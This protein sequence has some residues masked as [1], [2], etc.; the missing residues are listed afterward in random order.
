MKKHSLLVLLPFALI[1][2]GCG[3][4]GK[5]SIFN[6]KFMKRNFGDFR[7]SKYESEAPH[8]VNLDFGSGV[9]DVTHKGSGILLVTKGEERGLFSVHNGKFVLPVDKYDAGD[10]NTQ[11]ISNGSLGKKFFVGRKTVEEKVYLSV[12][13]DEANKLYEG[14]DGVVSI[15][16]NI[17]NRNEIEGNEYS[18]AK[19]NIDGVMKACAIYNVDQ[20]LKEILTEEQY[21]NKNPYYVSGI[22]MSNY[23]HK[24][25]YMAISQEVDVGTRCSAFNTKKGKFVSSFV[26]PDD[27]VCTITI[28]DHI[29]Y[30]KVR[31]CNERDKKYD[32]TTTPA[33]DKYN[34]ETYSVNY[35]TG[36]ETKIKTKY[37]FGNVNDDLDLVNNKG[38]IKY[39][40]LTGVYEVGKDKILSR[41]AKGLVFNEKLKVV[42]DVSGID[43]TTLYN[44]GDYYIS[45]NNVVYDSKLK[46]VGKFNSVSNDWH[47]VQSNGGY[48]LVDHTGK[49]IYR[50]TAQMIE[51]ISEGYY[52]AYYANK[53]QILK[54]S[55]KE[56]VEVSKEI[57]ATDYT[58]SDYTY[59][60]VHIILENSEHKL[61][62]LDLSSGSISELEVKGETDTLVGSYSGSYLGESLETEGSIYKSG[63]S[64]YVIR[65]SIKVTFSYPKY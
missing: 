50:P 16:A 52:I 21:A 10:E 38:I 17:M 15:T 1:V 49:F 45:D 35:L 31:Q 44:A 61:F 5:G 59:S 2:T 43:L 51:L 11:I 63:D 26:I 20:S 8:K 65:S 62:V 28:G 30:Q 37:F 57:L 12:Y 3:G 24:E 29:I 32:F 58:F 7:T 40:Y 22:R 4:L 46:E 36:K 34:F 27:V 47:I 19:V 48:G 55:D 60:M 6:E 33:G 23:G 39:E 13:D 54:M 53:I 64:Y 56:K 42:A 25:I 14:E 9:T 18:M 41:E